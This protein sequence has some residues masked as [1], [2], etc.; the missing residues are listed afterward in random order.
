[1]KIIPPDYEKYRRKDGKFY[2]V[3]RVDILDTNKF[4]IGSKASKDIN[5]NYYGSPVKRNEYYTL[6]NES[7]KNNYNNLVFTIIKWSTK[8]KRYIHEEEI[9]QLLKDNLNILNLNFRP[10]NCYFTYEQGDLNNPFLKQK[11]RIS[12]INRNKNISWA[13]VYNFNHP[14]YGNFECTITDFI[15]MFKNKYSVIMDRGM[16][17]LIGRYGHLRDGFP[18]EYKRKMPLKPTNKYYNWTCTN[19]IKE[20]YLRR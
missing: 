13:G 12:E 15:K 7:K 18:L 14:T 8:Q 11:E 6:L 19:V 5:D 9:L 1:M 20:P 3:Y 16:M 4:Y 2:F 10:T 17:N